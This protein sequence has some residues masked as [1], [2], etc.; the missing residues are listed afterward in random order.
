MSELSAGETVQA[1]H[2]RDELA[3]FVDRVN[4]FVDEQSRPV[5]VASNGSPSLG[6]RILSS[7][8]LQKLRELA[9]GLSNGLDAGRGIAVGKYNEGIAAIRDLAVDFAASDPTT[10]KT[11]AAHLA[12]TANDWLG[13]DGPLNAAEILATPVATA[14]GMVR[15]A[16][17][18]TEIPDLLDRLGDIKGDRSLSNPLVRTVLG[19]AVQMGLRV[20]QAGQGVLAS[21]L[22]RTGRLLEGIGTGAGAELAVKAVFHA[23][24]LFSEVTLGDFSPAG[25]KIFDLKNSSDNGI[26]I[27]VREK[28]SGKY[29]GFEVKA[30][31]TSRPPR[32]EGLQKKGADAFIATRLREIRDRGGV[33]GGDRVTQG[34]RD[35]A[36]RILREQDEFTGY[37]VQVTNYGKPTLEVNMMNPWVANTSLNRRR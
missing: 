9:L 13:R 21:Y 15:A 3:N 12:T 17:N 14:S 19:E 31:E 7:E 23:S 16:A 2:R 4:S 6:R 32:L 25:E 20:E 26:D 24:R 1:I 28:D 8:P 10:I 37:I 30:S 18:A 34:A 33:F 5:L 11:L 27:L 22:R 35:Y 36:E 29:V